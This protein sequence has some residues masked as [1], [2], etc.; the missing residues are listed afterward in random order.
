[1]DDRS[2]AR[3]IKREA[4]SI[5]NVNASSPCLANGNIKLKERFNKTNVVAQ[6]KFSGA[7]KV[8]ACFQGRSSLGQYCH[9]SLNNI[10]PHVILQMHSAFTGFEI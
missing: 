9:F 6:H 10:R 1:M 2:H 3:D 4:F 8:V 5:I 7:T